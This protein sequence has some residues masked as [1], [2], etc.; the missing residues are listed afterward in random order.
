LIQLDPHENKF[1]KIA[2][3]SNGQQRKYFTAY[4]STNK[5]NHRQELMVEI[6]YTEPV[7]LNEA[8]EMRKID[9]F[10]RGRS[11]PNGEFLKII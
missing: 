3:S 6:F 5:A 10:G 4:K 2:Y 7:S 1:L 8:D 9:T 11:L